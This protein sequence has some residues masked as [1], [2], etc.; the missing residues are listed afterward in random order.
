MRKKKIILTG[1]NGL[2]GSKFKQLFRT[3]YEIIN[4]DLSD[5]NNPLDITN[6][7]NL[8]QRFKKY[9]NIEAVVHMAAYT[10]VN[11]A[12]E[13]KNNKNGL[14]YKVNVIGTR[15]IAR[16][17][18]EFSIPLIH[19]STAYVFDGQK[20]SSYVEDDNVNPI[21]WYGQTKAYAEEEVVKVLKQYVIL[22]LD[23]PFRLDVFKKKDL[24]AKIINGLN[25]K[26]LYPQFTNHYFG[27][28]FV[29][30]F[31]F[32]VD[33][34]LKNLS[35]TGSYHSSSGEKW[36]DYDFSNLVRLNLKNDYN[37]RKSDLFEYLKKSVRPYQQ[38]TSL[39]NNKLKKILNFEI[40]KITDVLQ[41]LIL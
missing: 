9:S 11:K 5:Q 41:R 17:C 7:K 3:K 34:F 39:N 16:C 15:N 14:V 8:N 19:L 12:F 6:F 21:E 29:D 20:K 22:R 36:N 40:S 24:L 1:S 31:C 25:N 28:T 33:F 26:T 35:I 10:D 4:F 2:I 13:E 27:P 37:I 32:I 23:Q 38:N 18:C 30:D